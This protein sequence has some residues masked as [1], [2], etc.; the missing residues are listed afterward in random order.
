MAKLN[1]KDFIK[2]AN[3]IYI[4]PTKEVL[5]FLK[6]EYDLI[7]KNLEKFKQ[8]DVSKVEPL[9]RISEP[10]NFLRE[11]EFDTSIILDK[12]VILDNSTEKDSNYVLIKRILK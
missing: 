7:E 11:D 4:E 12:E 8:I 5:D 10:I 3:K 2:M 9:V 1:E 6:E